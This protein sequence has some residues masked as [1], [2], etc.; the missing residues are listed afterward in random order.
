VFNPPLEQSFQEGLFA[1]HLQEELNKLQAD[2]RF[3]DFTHKL[4]RIRDRLY[5]SGGDAKFG[6]GLYPAT[7]GS[8]GQEEL[9]K[10]AVRDVYYPKKGTNEAED[11]L[12]AGKW[13]EIAQRTPKEQVECLHRTLFGS[14]P[15]E[16]FLRSQMDLPDFVNADSVL[17]KFMNNPYCE[18]PHPGCTLPC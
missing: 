9:I 2:F 10:K 17:S 7:K 3:Q 6:S 12:L 8:S 18:P 16:H 14:S 11:E 4:E 1:K 13:R 5:G 15:W